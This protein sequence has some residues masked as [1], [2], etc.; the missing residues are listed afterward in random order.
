VPLWRA[1]MVELDES[2]VDLA[3]AVFGEEVAAPVLDGP[4]VRGHG[5][6]VLAGGGALGEEVVA[7]PHARPAGA[8]AAP[9]LLLRRRPCAQQHD[10]YLLYFVTPRTHI[11][12]RR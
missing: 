4:L 12:T 1:A 11:Y 5:D 7:G 8:L 9:A 2:L 6:A 3:A 10:A